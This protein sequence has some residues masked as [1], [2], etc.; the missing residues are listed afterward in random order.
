VPMSNHRNTARLFVKGESVGRQTIVFGQRGAI[1]GRR[2]CRKGY[3]E[4]GQGFKRSCSGWNES[5]GRIPTGNF[6]AM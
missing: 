1:S 3:S 2:V 5:F 6:G 4:D